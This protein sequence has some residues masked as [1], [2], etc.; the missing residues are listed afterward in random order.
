MTLAVVA[1]NLFH[2]LTRSLLLSYAFMLLHR[3]NLPTQ[4]T[5]GAWRNVFITTAVIYFVSCTLYLAVTPV[6]QQEWDNPTPTA[7]TKSSCSPNPLLEPRAGQ[8]E[9]VEC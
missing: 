3:I 2:S 8:E 9:P 6:R 4:Q 5:L 1:P 7:A